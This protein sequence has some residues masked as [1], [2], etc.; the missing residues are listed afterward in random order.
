MPDEDSS[1]RIDH[2]DPL[3]GLRLYLKHGGTLRAAAALTGVSRSTLQRYLSQGLPAAA[4]DCLVLVGMFRRDGR[5]R[6]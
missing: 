1:I 3:S 5:I 2:A 6:K 4:Q